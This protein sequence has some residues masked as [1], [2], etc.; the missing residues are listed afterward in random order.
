MT[1]LSGAEDVERWTMLQRLM[2]S[3]SILLIFPAAPGWLHT[4]QLVI[5]VVTLRECFLAGAVETLRTA[6]VIRRTGWQRRDRD[7]VDRANLRERGQELAVAIGLDHP[8]AHRN[9][10][11]VLQPLANRSLPFRRPA[12]RHRRSAAIGRA[13]TVAART[14]A[15]KHTNC[16]WHPRPANDAL[17]RYGSPQIHPARQMESSPQHSSS[18]RQNAPT[19]AQ[20]LQISVVGAAGKA[21]A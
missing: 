3:E 18:V 4:R 19:G 14:H 6:I 10:L 8:D 5:P 15:R 13:W 2:W 20:S 7:G 9:L 16:G 17:Q 21:N 12:A 1:P 11:L